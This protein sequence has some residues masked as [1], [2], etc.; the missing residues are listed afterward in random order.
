M[1]PA[2]RCWLVKLN[3]WQDMGFDA[4]WISPITQ[5][6]ADPSRAYTGYIQTN[7]YGTNANFGTPDQLRS[8]SSA[9]KSRGMVRGLG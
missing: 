7:L 1:V 8:L 6:V 2:A 9:L 5:Q 4:I 3:H